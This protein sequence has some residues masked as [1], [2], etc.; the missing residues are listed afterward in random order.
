LA[1]LPAEI[2]GQTRGFV[3]F[4]EISFSTISRYIK[5][6][7]IQYEDLNNCTEITR[8]KFISIGHAQFEI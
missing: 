4:H 8:Q 5:F 1:A 2:S 6:E 3:S 7:V